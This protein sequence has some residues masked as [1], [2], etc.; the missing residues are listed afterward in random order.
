MSTKIKEHSSN[1]HNLRV[2]ADHCQVNEVL[3]SIGPRWKMQILFCIS[4]E[5]YQFSRLKKVFPSISDQILGKRLCELVTE[6]LTVKNEI[7][8]TVPL[9]YKYEVTAKGMALL[10]IVQ[11]LHLWGLKDWNINR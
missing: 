8:D 9:Q 1:A 10:E 6:N 2:L 5:V 4:K 11:Q 7:P 3:K